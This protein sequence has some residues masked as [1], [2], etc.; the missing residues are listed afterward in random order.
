MYYVSKHIGHSVPITYFVQDIFHPEFML[1]RFIL[2]SYK[3]FNGKKKK[4]QVMQMQIKMIFL[5][6]NWSMSRGGHGL[7]PP[8]SMSK[9]FFYCMYCPPLILYKVDCM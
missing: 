1:N 8:V 3:D 9:I 7:D 4:S 6:V 5:N 2:K